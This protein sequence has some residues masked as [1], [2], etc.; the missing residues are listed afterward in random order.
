MTNFPTHT[1]SLLNPELCLQATDGPPAHVKKTIPSAT[2]LTASST[3]TPA[4]S[5]LQSVVA[6]AGGIGSSHQRRANT[7]R[8]ELQQLVQQKRE[9]CSAERMAKHMMESAE[10]ESRPPPPGT[11]RLLIGYCLLDLVLVLV[12][13][14]SKGKT[15]VLVL[16]MVL[17]LL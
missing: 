5:V 7:C 4:P 12:L 14:L 11:L 9:Q 2:A 1:E 13:A 6:G 8:A 3:A 10:W 15:L 16:A 17:G